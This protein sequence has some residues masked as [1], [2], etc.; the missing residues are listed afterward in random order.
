M[1]DITVAPLNGYLVSFHQVM[2]RCSKK[3]CRCS[4]GLFHGPYWVAR[5]R[6]AHG[7]R[8]TLHIGKQLPPI[9][10]RLRQLAQS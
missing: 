1:K 6:N 9:L 7:D 5:L 10:T 8:K 2:R 4:K 3:G